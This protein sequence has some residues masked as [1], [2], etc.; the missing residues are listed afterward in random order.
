MFNDGKTYQWV[1]LIL[2][3]FIIK[4]PIKLSPNDFRIHYNCCLGPLFHPELQIVILNS[5][6]LSSLYLLYEV[7]QRTFYQLVVFHFKIFF[8]LLI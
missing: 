3:I 7:L 5:I 2:A 1:Q 8:I 6:I 4:F